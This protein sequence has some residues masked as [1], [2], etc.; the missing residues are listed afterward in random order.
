MRFGAWK[1]TYLAVRRLLHCHCLGQNLV[2][3][4]GRNTQCL[5]LNDHINHII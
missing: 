5:I 2:Q 3:D 4:T 1:G